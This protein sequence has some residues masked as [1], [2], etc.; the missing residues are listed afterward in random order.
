M[1]ARMSK[2]CPPRDDLDSLLNAAVTRFLSLPRQ[3][4]REAHRAQRRSW[5]VGEL[6]LSHADMTREH[7][8]RIYDEVSG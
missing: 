1:S 6:M 2:P 7:A 4:Q 8:E 5:V 3:L